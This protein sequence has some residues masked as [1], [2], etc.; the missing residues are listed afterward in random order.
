MSQLISLSLHSSERVL[1]P[2]PQVTEH[3]KRKEK[4]NQV[5]KSLLERRYQ[6][7]QA[8]TE[9]FLTLFTGFNT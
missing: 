8:V 6:I 3:C 2:E 9:N 5:H 4:G 7:T 1:T